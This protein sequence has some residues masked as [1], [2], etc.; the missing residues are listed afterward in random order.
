MK[1]ILRAAIVSAVAGAAALAVA[2]PVIAQVGLTLNFG[3][4]AIGYRDGYYD[5]HH[6]WHHWR[7]P[8]DY[9]DYGRAHPDH[10]RDY[11]HD[12]DDHPH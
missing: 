4:V 1:S 11:G 8:N 10:Y 3:D 2:T 6:V 9:R 12:R 5:G 7:H